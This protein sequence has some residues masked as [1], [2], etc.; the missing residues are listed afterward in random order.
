MVISR[1]IRASAICFEKCIIIDWSNCG[2]SGVGVLECIQLSILTLTM[3]MICCVETFWTNNIILSLPI[4][5]CVAFI[6]FCDRYYFD[7]F[8]SNPS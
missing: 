3:M 5:Q 8:K 1:A 2:F 4:N 6:I 7:D